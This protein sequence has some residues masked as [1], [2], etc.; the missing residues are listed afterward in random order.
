MPEVA[1]AEALLAQAE[2]AL[3]QFALVAP[4][5][6]TILEITVAKGETLGGTS[7]IPAIQ[8]CPDGP[9]IVRADVDQASAARVRVG[10]KVVMEDDTNSGGIWTGHVKWVADMFSQQRPVVNPDPTQY[11]DVR[12]M[13]CVIDLDPHQPPLKINQRLLATI[14]VPA[15]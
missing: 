7:P 10:Q 11:S 13:Q 3:T 15:N 12:T 8:F 4:A 6:G 2:A 1:R 9:R 5:A 14:E